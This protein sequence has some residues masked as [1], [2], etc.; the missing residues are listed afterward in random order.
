MSE[1]IVKLENI[2]KEFPGVVALNN[3][4]LSLF[5]GRVQALVG[6]N[7]AGKSTLMKILSGTYKS[8]D[9]DVRLNGKV[10][11]FHSEKDALDHGISIV[12]QELNSVPE[13]TI[14]ENIFLG[15]EPMKWKGSILDKKERSIKTAEFLSCLGLNYDPEAKMAELSVAQRQM[16]EIIK[17][18]SR[19][20]RVII[21]DEPTSALTELET[22]FLF[23]QIRSL[24]D[25][26]MAI[27]FIS[28]KL[29]EVMAISDDVAV[30]RDG[31]M[32]GSAK[33]SEISQ[34][35]MITMMVGREIQDIY[36]ELPKP[37]EP[38]V[39]KAENLCSEGLFSDVSF[40]VHKGEI[41]GFAGMMG[42][43]RSEI[44]RTIFG[45]DKFDS[46]YLYLSGK[47]IS[48]HSVSDAIRNGIAM[49]TEDRSTYGFVGVRS[50]QE[51]ITI[52]NLDIFSKHSFLQFSAI[53]TKAGAICRKMNVKAPSMDTLVGTLSG[54]NQQKVVLSKWLVRNVDL[55]ILDE[56]TR[57]IDVAAKQEIYKMIAAL[58][59]SGIAILLVASEMP[60]VLA[61]SHRVEVIAEGHILGELSGAEATQENIMKMIVKERRS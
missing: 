59:E 31:E 49:V 3:V 58:A 4:N 20:S 8:Y 36:P 50:I 40:E 30:L 33:T 51:N 45:L 22:K 11:H 21:L 27:V 14:A 54:G 28:H 52:P 29:E 9:G 6:E 13:M 35:E 43:G 53:K 42:A 16:V 5:P 23:E 44:M 60:E 2:R 55:L 38:V 57:G 10:V 26:S 48:V 61:M 7:G 41:L 37:K 46:G 19:Q 15:R 34:D 12:S 18:I 1:A 32:V 24:R 17:A 56:P 39:F 25:K 47:E